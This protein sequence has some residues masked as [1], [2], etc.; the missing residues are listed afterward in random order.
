[1]KEFRLS[2]GVLKEEAGAGPLYPELTAGALGTP[3]PLLIGG[4]LGTPYPLLIGG[5]LGTPYPLLMGGALGTPYPL[6]GLR[7]ASEL[8]ED[9]IRS[10][11]T[12]GWRAYMK[13]WVL[14][15]KVWA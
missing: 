13:V 5:A 12:W 4:A 1:M 3:Y 15:R 6:E 8:Y 7:V 10:Q 14:R 9:D 11:Q 2:C